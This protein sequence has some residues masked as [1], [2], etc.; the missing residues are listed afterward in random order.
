MHSCAP[1]PDCFRPA[2][3]YVKDDTSESADRALVVGLLAPEVGLEPTTLRLTAECSAIELLRNVHEVPAGF[4][5]ST[6]RFSYN[7]AAVAGQRAASK[8]SRDMPSEETET[9]RSIALNA[10]LHQLYAL[11]WTA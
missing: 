7:K 3:V 5:S 9:T 6:R 10:A 8:R 11:D 1:R 4:V 2:E